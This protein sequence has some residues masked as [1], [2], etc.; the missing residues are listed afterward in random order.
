[1]K[2]NIGD[3]PRCVITHLL[4][5]ASLRSQL[6]MSAT[7]RNFRYLGHTKEIILIR[8]VLARPELLQDKFRIFEIEQNEPLIMEQFTQRAL[9]YLITY[10]KLSKIPQIYIA[11]RHD[12]WSDFIPALNDREVY[13]D[14]ISC[15]WTKNTNF[16]LVIDVLNWYVKKFGEYIEFNSYDFHRDILYYNKCAILKFITAY[17]ISTEQQLENISSNR[18]FKEDMKL[19]ADLLIMFPN[20][21][22]EDRIIYDIK[23]YPKVAMITILIIDDQWHVNRN[24][25]LGYV[26]SHGT[27]EL[28]RYALTNDYLCEDAIRLPWYGCYESIDNLIMAIY[29]GIGDINFEYLTY[30]VVLRYYM[31]QLP[32]DIVWNLKR[33]RRNKRKR[34]L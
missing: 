24:R 21:L 29:Y 4:S 20:I 30:E 23:Y 6:N 15:L 10:G 28:I 16:N 32:E 2:K 17:Y 34:V 9:N 18:V 31:N 25:V 22:T 27:K 13:A 11:V 19:F 12:S 3:I 5:G 26:I 14:V 7:C 33:T 1:M 8:R